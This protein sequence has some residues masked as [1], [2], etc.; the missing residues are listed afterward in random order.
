MDIWGFLFSLNFVCLKSF[1]IKN[2]K[3]Q[4]KKSDKDIKGNET[5]RE[6]KMRKRRRK[7]EEKR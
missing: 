6:R 7:E 4:R 3:F 5:E 2:V 1:I